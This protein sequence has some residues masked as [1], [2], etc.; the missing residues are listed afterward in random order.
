METLATRRPRSLRRGMSYP[1][2]G[3]TSMT[4]VVNVEASRGRVF[5]P[6]SVTLPA[7]LLLLIQ[8]GMAR[9]YKLA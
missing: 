1:G 9:I 3:I 8:M 7:H 6:G 4:N 2:D 5:M